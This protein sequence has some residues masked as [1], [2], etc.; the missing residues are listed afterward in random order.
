M[1]GIDILEDVSKI[2]Q[3]ILLFSGYALHWRLSKLKKERPLTKYESFLKFF[4]MLGILTWALSF[5]LL[6]MWG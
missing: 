2:G 1:N 6:F 4:V 3:L 5:F